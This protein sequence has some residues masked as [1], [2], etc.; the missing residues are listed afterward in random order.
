MLCIK[1]SEEPRQN[2]KGGA[3]CNTAQRV[4]SLP[5]SSDL[6]QTREFDLSF[7]ADSFYRGMSVKPPTD[8]KPHILRK[9]GAILA[10]VLA[11]VSLAI[12]RAYSPALPGANFA[13]A[14][15][16]LALGVGYT[17]PPAKLS[18]RGAGEV[19]VAFTHSLLV[20]QCGAT[21]LGGSFGSLQIWAIGVPLFLSVLPSITI[22]GIPDRE[23]DQA[24]DERSLAVR[25]GRTGA[26][27]IAMGATA[28]SLLTVFAMPLW[29]SDDV[30][31][32]ISVS[33]MTLHGLFLLHQLE[34]ERAHPR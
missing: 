28:A 12:V 6:H 13:L 17:V 8:C 20:V 24:A 5:Q 15:I 1:G 7:R 27:V 30:W 4:Q 26:L 21:F 9:R 22:S 10:G 14:G 31:P 34:M 25:L 23:A 3:G 11:F 29:A 33:G 16:A 18:H 2:A 32:L 19:V